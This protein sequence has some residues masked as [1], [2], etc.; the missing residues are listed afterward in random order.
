MPHDRTNA[1]LIRHGCTG[2]AGGVRALVPG[3]GRWHIA[4]VTEAEPKLPPYQQSLAGTLLAAREAVMAPIRP[5][6]R[7]ANVTEQQWRV[8]RVLDH[9]GPTDPTS[10]AEAALLF[11]P[12]VARILKELVERGLIVRAPHARDR[13][14]AVLTLSPAGEAL[15]RQTSRRTLAQ[16]DDY[17]ARF[18]AQRLERL[19][20]ELRAFTAAIGSGADRAPG[21]ADPP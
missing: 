6:L 11:A 15:I 20:D 12:S 19:I 7:N 17:A 2:G 18:G 4:S 8:L 3:V 10:L 5:M 1:P 16:L 9:A 13:R 21:R 14:R